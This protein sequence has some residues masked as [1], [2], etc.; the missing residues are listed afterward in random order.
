MHAQ[1]VATWDEE[2]MLKS[3]LLSPIVEAHT[4]PLRSPCFLE[5]QQGPPTEI[6]RHIPPHPVFL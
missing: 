5:E 3:A 4:Q 1:V 6:S 2:A